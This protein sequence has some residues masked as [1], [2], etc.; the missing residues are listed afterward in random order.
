MPDVTIKSLRSFV[1]VV[2]ER[3][4]AKAARRLGIPQSRIRDQVT[5]LEKAIG[6]R[7]LERRFPINRAE[8]GRTQLTAEGRAFLP[9][10]VEVVRAYDRMFDAPTGLDLRERNRAMAGRLMEMALAALN[11]DLSDGDQERIDALLD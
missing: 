8:T 5:A 10:A 11:H 9:K 7:L 4:T 6:H 3:S 2:E 1:A